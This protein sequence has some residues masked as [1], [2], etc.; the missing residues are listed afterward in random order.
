MNVLRSA[1]NKL[2]G[3]NG[4]GDFPAQVPFTDDPC[5]VCAN[6]CD[7]GHPQIPEYLQRKIDQ[8]PLANSIKPY[9]RHILVISG[10]SSRWQERLEDESGSWVE[11][12]HQG[13]S[14][15]KSINKRTLVTACDTM[16]ELGSNLRLSSSLATSSEDI[17]S[18]TS[19]PTPASSSS[20]DTADVLLFP[21]AL[22]IPNVPKTKAQETAKSLSLIGHP[23]DD[24]PSSPLPESEIAWIMVCTHKKRDKRC[25][26]AGP[27]LVQEFRN[28]VVELGMEG[29]VRVFG[30]SHFGGHKFAG[31]VIIYHRNP[32]VTGNWYGR[33]TSC[34]VRP[35]LQSTVKEGKIF[36]QLWRGKMDD[37]EGV[38]ATVDKVD[39]TW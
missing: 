6:P 14:A 20:P 34:E 23:P 26:V 28:A 11:I 1:V 17:P 25:G 37:P 29:Q 31:N 27:L 19:T 30:V 32:I 33:V 35:I 13:A 36:K 9:A 16:P 22:S 24:I 38:G 21:E 18:T 3:G 4:D 39:K 12:V 10:T 5:R 15:S 2:V 8:S 7:Q